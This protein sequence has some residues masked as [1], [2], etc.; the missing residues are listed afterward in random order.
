MSLLVVILVIAAILIPLWVLLLKDFAGGLAYAVFFWVCMTTF[1][2]VSLGGALPELTIHRLMLI[3]VTGAWLSRQGVRELSHVPMLGCFIFWFIANL[4]SLCGTNIDFINSL[5]RFLDFVLELFAFFVVISTSLRSS[6]DAFRVLRG[7]WLGLLA[8]AV[9]AILERYTG[10]NPVDHFIP[11]YVRDDVAM[12]DIL[13]TYQHRILL[14]TAMAMG[15]PISFALLER[16]LQIG[17]VPRFFWFGIIL[18]VSACYFAFSRGPWMGLGLACAILALF[19]SFHV[20]KR[21]ATI[22]VLAALVLV[23]RPGVFDTLS[24]FAHDT[25][26]SDSFKG[27]TFQYRLELWRVAAGEVSKSPW[28]LLF[29]YGP[30]AG[31]EMEIQH[32]LSYRGKTQ[33]I[34]SWDNHFAYTLFQSGFVGLAATLLLYFKAAIS[35]F[36]GA[37]QSWSA[38]R[39]LLGCLFAAALVQIWMMTNVLIF[40]KQ[41]DYL[42]WTLVACGF[43]LARQ[44]EF[45]SEVELSREIPE[46]IAGET[47]AC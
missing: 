24:G 41:L 4:I 42:F 45:A 18:F 8:V 36:Y 35:L 30:G 19:G 39:P 14:G 37:R 9:L 20:K 3:I 16:R 46:G 22:G 44:P 25:A 7:A 29:G 38:N 28:R 1:L 47:A 31:S 33:K 32:E 13:S 6:G 17:E 26:D 40:A 2:R 34:E 5:K 21:L 23:A 27:G 15:V 12:H 11:G 10:F 43:A